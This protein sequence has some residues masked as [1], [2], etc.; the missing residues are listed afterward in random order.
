MIWPGETD[1][2]DCQAS[3]FT[4]LLPYI[5]QDNTH[6]L[7]HF[8]EPWFNPPNYQAVGTEVKL[9]FCPSNRS[10]GLLDL[11]P[12]AQQW[13]TTL[14]PF[15]ACL[16][17]ALCRGATGALHQDAN[18]APT[19][20]RGVFDVRQGEQATG[21]VR[22]A[23]ITDG[24]SATFAIGDA[25]AGTPGLLVRDLNNPAQAIIDPVTGQAAV[26][27]QSWGAAGCG[28]LY[29]PW[30]GSVLATTAQYGLAPDPRDEPMNRALLTPTAWGND[31][32]GDN[33]TGRDWISGFRS[34][35]NGGCNVV[36]C[37]GGVRFIRQTIEP[38]T[39]RALSTYAGGEVVAQD[40]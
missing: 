33:R 3:G 5:E 26:S 2:T 18:R 38:A 36:F 40:Y 35:H 8:E 14:P 20:V 4:R 19:A 15:A 30:Y 13:A 7:Y 25:A 23:D 10:G 9:F 22:L 24:T 31:P 34:R 1:T 16:D 11:A 28:D 17:Y 6:K 39:Y 37:D 27:E 12:M 29:H 32:Y 21:A